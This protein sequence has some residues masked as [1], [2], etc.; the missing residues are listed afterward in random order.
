[1]T[2]NTPRIHEDLLWTMC[3]QLLSALQTIHGYGLAC[4]VLD[5]KHVLVLERNRYRIGSVGVMDILEP[6]SNIKEC[7]SNDLRQLGYLLFI[8]ASHSSTINI[9]LIRDI[10]SESFVNVVHY[11]LQ[12]QYTASAL[13]SQCVPHIVRN[14]NCVMTATDWYSNMLVP[15]LKEFHCSTE[16]T[17]TAAICAC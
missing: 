15:L 10:Y 6:R 3:I 8:L 11:L 14:L 4:R 12:G 13:L 17:R 1:M 2:P 5:D 7:Q 9:D 16:S